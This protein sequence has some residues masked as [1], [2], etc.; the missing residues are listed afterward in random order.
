MHTP[1][2][3][4]VFIVDDLRSM[5]ER[6]IEFLGEIDGLVVVGEAGSPTEAIDGILRLRPDFVVLDYQLEGGTGLEVLRGV[7]GI[8]SAIVFAILTHHATAQHRRACLAA[9]ATHFLDKSHELGT[10]RSLLSGRIAPRTP[11]S[12]APIDSR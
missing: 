8:D 9:G 10:L 7:H 1:A 4:R 6:L 2:V 3:T 12:H 11:S 5:R